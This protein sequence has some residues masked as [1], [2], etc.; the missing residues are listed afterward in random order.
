MKKK[1]MA[2]LMVVVAIV[3]SMIV[4]GL[5]AEAKPQLVPVHEFS[6]VG[7]KI[8]YHIPLEEGAAVFR[9]HHDDYYFRVWLLNRVGISI[10]ELGNPNVRLTRFEHDEVQTVRI[11]EKGDYGLRIDTGGKWTIT[12]E[13]PI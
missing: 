4:A 10:E 7:F 12:V 5:T 8:I 6:G 1:T 11:E 2:S 13:Q 9:I 3:A